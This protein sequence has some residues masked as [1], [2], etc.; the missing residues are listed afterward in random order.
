MPFTVQRIDHVEVL[1]R[2]LAAAAR[3]YQRTLGL[4][5]ICRW[6]P[7][8]VMIGAGHTKLALFQAPDGAIPAATQGTLHWHRVAWA[9]DAGGF[10]AAQKHLAQLGIACRGP[11]DHGIAQ[12]IYFNDPDGNPLE[13]TY[14][15]VPSRW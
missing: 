11:V 5:E 15:C 12:S 8:P 14:Y 1:V 4:E 3:W 2:D 9:T 13:I 7:E 10:A 6:E